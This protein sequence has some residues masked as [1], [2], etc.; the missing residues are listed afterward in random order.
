MGISGNQAQSSCECVRWFT[1]DEV[2]QTMG[3]VTWD[4][5]VC[6]ALCPMGNPGRVSGAEEESDQTG[7]RADERGGGCQLAW[8]RESRQ[9]DQR[10]P[11][12][13]EGFSSHCP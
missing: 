1:G 13:G 6:F 9:G 8:G 3:S 12:G 4:K 2:D 11:N 5:G 7:L 10:K